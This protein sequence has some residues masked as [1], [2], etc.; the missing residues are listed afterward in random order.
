[1]ELLAA[2][3]ECIIDE[4]GKEAATGKAD[5][6]GVLVV[7]LAQHTTK[8]GQKTEAAAYTVTMADKR[9]TID[10]TEYRTISMR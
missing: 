6:K 5:D 3:R 8:G 10:M 7:M 4:D 2:V 9:Q 1:M